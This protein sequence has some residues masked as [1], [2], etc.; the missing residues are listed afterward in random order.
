LP[1]KADKFLAALAAIVKLDKPA[2]ADAYQLLL[3]YF[4]EIPGAGVNLLTEILHAMD[5]KR[6]AVMNQ[7]A[8]SGLSLTNI[9]DFPIKPNKISVSAE[10]YARYCQKADAVRTKLGL[11]D[12]TE[13]DALFNYAYW[14]HDEDDEVDE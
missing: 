4:R 11:S 2:T 14:R 7:N 8:V 12:F 5:C 3:D 9:N 10:L 13:L 6:F 1:K